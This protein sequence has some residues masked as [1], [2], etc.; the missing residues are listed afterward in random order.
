M[1]ENEKQ[2]TIPYF[3]HEATID[4][5]DRNNKRLLHALIVVC[6]TLFIT[7]TSLV[8]M[9]TTTYKNLSNSFINYI[10][11]HQIEVSADGVYEQS[12]TQSD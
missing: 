1:S 2:A 4:K 8:L 5:M 3:V 12:D 6:V 9:F 11:T 10:E 7:V